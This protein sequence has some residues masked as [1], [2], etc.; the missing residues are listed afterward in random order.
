[1][2]LAFKII[3]LSFDVTN[4]QTISKLKNKN[5]IY[6]HVSKQMQIYGAC[7]SQ[8]QEFGAKCFQNIAKNS[9]N[10]QTKIFAALPFHNSHISGIWRLIRQY[11]NPLSYLH[12]G[13]RIN[14]F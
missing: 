2:F 3:T 11:G 6:V 9:T 13:N 5:P 14:G 1:M 7:I 10:L 4:F 12:L 8:N